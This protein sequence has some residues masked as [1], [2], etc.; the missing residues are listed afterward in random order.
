MSVMLSNKCL[1]AWIVLD[2]IPEFAK[3]NIRDPD[4]KSAEVY[5]MTRNFSRDSGYF[6]AVKFRNDKE[7]GFILI[8]TY[9]ESFWILNDTKGYDICKQNHIQPRMFSLSDGCF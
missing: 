4:T 1:Y 2:V 5:N 6:T 8:L 7:H 9:V 3:A